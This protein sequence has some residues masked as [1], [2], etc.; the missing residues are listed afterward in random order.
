MDILLSFV[1]LL[2]SLLDL[3][4]DSKTSIKL[5]EPLESTLSLCKV[6]PTCGV[7]LIP[8]FFVELLGISKFLKAAKTSG[9]FCEL[10]GVELR[11]QEGNN[12]IPT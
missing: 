1:K 11:K 8:V 12:C 10:L 9:K 6:F 3:Q 5:I 7:F 4:E 2:E